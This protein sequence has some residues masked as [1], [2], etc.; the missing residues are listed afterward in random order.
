MLS[1]F[2]V[3]VI[4]W[5][6][7]KMFPQKFS[8]IIEKDILKKTCGQRFQIKYSELSMVSTNKERSI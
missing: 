5:N 3:N 8:I 7:A 4:V 2:T 1:I 6:P